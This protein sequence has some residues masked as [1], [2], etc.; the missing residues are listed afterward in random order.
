ML[1]GEHF[2]G[3]LLDQAGDVGGQVAVAVV[4]PCG[5]FLDQRQGV[6]HR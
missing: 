3:G 2:I 1:A 4:D 6:Q 5:G